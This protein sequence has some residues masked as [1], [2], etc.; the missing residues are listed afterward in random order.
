MADAGLT[1]GGFYAHF[2]SKDDFLAATV[3]Q[4]FEDSPI[5]MILGDQGQP[6][7]TLLIEFLEFY[8]SPE[9]RDTRTGG[10]PLPFL[11][12]EAPRL[13]PGLRARLSQATAR[14]IKLLSNHLEELGRP[15]PEEEASSIVSEIIGAVILARAEPDPQCSDALLARSRASVRRRLELENQ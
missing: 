4:M 9:H 10:C 1:H 11:T 6:V 2:A 15:N 3:G 8:L 12:A 13:I 7:R 5:A 14:M